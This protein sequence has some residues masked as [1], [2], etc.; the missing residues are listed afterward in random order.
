MTRVKICGLSRASDVEAAVDSGADSLG[1]ISGY[2]NS[3]RN[4]TFDKL[5]ELISMVP[6][7]VDTVVVT[8]PWN[9]DFRKII[10][11][12]P[13]YIQMYVDSL[14]SRKTIYRNVIETI[15]PAVDY[16]TTVEK[17][18]RLSKRSKA[19]LFDAS[20]TSR[21]SET[22]DGTER[23]MTLQECWRIARSVKKA[24]GNTPLILGGGLTV[25]NVRRAIRYVQPYAVDVSSGVESSPGRK[26]EEKIFHFVRNAKKS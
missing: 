20:V 18:V 2:I 21:Y 16:G 15:R 14:H 3:P 6:L 22:E 1:F 26:D 25:N 11:L 19:I 9:K 13:G 7:F 8:P 5:E 24:I 4:L 17:A 10:R 12:A 23:G